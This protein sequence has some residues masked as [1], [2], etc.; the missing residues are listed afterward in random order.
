MPYLILFFLLISCNHSPLSNEI[1]SINQNSKKNHSWKELC[2]NSPDL[3]EIN[4]NERFHYDN[5]EKNIWINSLQE[6]TKGIFL[7]VHGLNLKP[8]KMNTIANYWSS[9]GYSVLRGTLSGH[10]GSKEEML[11][12]TQKK[13]RKDVTNLICES[14]N[15]SRQNNVPL[16]FLGYSLGA[17]TLLDTIK[18]MGFPNPFKKMIL[19]APAIRIKWFA[20]LTKILSFFSSKIMIP[21]ASLI[22]YRSQSGTSTAAYTALHKI[23]ENIGPSYS[24]LNIPTLIYLDPKDELISKYDLEKL[25]KYEELNN[26]NLK[27]IRKEDSPLKKN[28]HH[29]II[30]PLTLGKK[31]FQQMMENLRNFIE[32][33]N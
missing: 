22:D 24:L 13:W 23:I 5:A 16:Y 14:L 3:H 29:L 33:Q 12:I 32:I 9:K 17:A 31:P 8:S 27:L 25:S 28:Y 6:N 21:S 26:W 15:E 10:F 2:E 11:T 1:I 4:S 20:N 18:S 7:I 19:L 30:D